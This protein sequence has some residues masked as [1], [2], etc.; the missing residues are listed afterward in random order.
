MKERRAGLMEKIN[1]PESM[2]S[3][4]ETVLFVRKVEIFPDS[5]MRKEIETLFGY[6]RW[7]WNQGLEL[8]N[9]QYEHFLEMKDKK[10]RPSEHKIRDALV[11][12]KKDWQ[13]QLSA[14]VLQTAVKDLGEAWKKYL[15]KDLPN[16]GKPKFKSKKSPFQSFRTDRASIK[17][18]KLRLDKPRGSKTV[19]KDI[20]FSGADLPDGKIRQLTVSRKNGRYYA[21]ITIDRPADEKVSVA[22]TGKITAVDAN[23]GHF[24]YALDAKAFLGRKRQYE[25]DTADNGGVLPKPVDE[26]DDPL[27]SKYPRVETEESCSVLTASLLKTYEKIAHYQAML[28]RKRVVNG[29]DEAQLSNSYQRVKT[30]LARCYER[31]ENIQGDILHKFTTMLARQYD[32]IV[33]EDLNVA[34]MKM[35]IA[36]KG[37][38]RSMFGQ[39]REILEYKCQKHQ[40]KLIKAPQDYP[41]TQ[42]CPMCGHRKSGDDKITLYGNRKH[43]TKHNEYI[44]Y[45]CGHTADRDAN[46]VWNLLNYGQALLSA[47]GGIQ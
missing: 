28:A 34:A 38:H 1:I 41:S 39:F 40:K 47:A 7:V 33:I 17:D 37:L 13:Y 23:V 9:W 31:A 22:A 45:E 26:R 12:N 35:G 30:K 10:D 25:K 29:K 21:S 11:A 42:L 14:R 32:T 46:A 8:W 18:G 44:C 6:R 16:T 5:V 20:R 19:F 3:D 36:S 4:A 15:R 43:R 24:D 27:Y 2:S